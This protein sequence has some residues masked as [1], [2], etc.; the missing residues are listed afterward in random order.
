MSGPFK[1]SS[2]TDLELYEL[3]KCAYPDRFPDLA[4]GDDWDSVME[5]AEEFQGLE[6]LCELLGRVVMLTMPMK[7]AIS[8]QL[9]YC[10]GE[11]NISDNQASMISAVKRNVKI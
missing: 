1:F 9:S 2:L 10:L 4:E 8:G 6:A 5:F 7:T 11:V 3:I